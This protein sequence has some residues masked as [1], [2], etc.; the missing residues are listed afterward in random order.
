MKDLIEET[1]LLFGAGFPQ[2]RCLR[3]VRYSV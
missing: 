3:A 2:E 1:T